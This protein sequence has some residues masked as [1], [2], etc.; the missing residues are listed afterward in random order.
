M[1]HI[2]SQIRKA[3]AKLITDLPLSDL[4]TVLASKVMNLTAEH[5]IPGVQVYFDDGTIDL[6]YLQGQEE[7]DAILQVEILAS[8]ANNVDDRLDEIS[9]QIEPLLNANKKLDGLVEQMTLKGFGYTR[10]DKTSLASLTLT[11][12]VTF[13]Q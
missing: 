1:T 5:H 4:R 12:R 11:Y 2:R 13:N 3:V 10:D 9:A 7:N 6:K 8:D